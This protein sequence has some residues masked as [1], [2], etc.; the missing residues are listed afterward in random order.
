[1]SPKAKRAKAFTLIELLVVVGII[2]VLIAILLPVLGKARRQAQLTVCMSNLRQLGIG[3]LSYA[4]DHRGWFPAPATAE[5]ANEED[6]VY[7]QPDRDVTESQIFRYIGNNLAVL[8]CPAGPPESLGHAGYPPYPF[9]YS[10]N[11]S[12]T[13]DGALMRFGSWSTI[14][15]NVNRV[16]LA[17]HKALL[18]EEDVTAIGDGD[19]NATGLDYATRIQSSVSVRHQRGPEIGAVTTKPAAY[20]D[21]SVGKGPVFFVDGHVD[22]MSRA[23]LAHGRHHD[24]WFR[25]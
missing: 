8:V 13:G 17:S 4:H 20:W 1:M 10:V 9:N 15:C 18:I 5:R 16:L 7:W 24:P 21:L 22:L 12:I 2:S 3:F 23:S 19:W 6:W 25:D 11:N 14:P